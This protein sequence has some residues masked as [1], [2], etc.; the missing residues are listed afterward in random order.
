MSI[1]CLNNLKALSSA[2]IYTK[3]DSFSF[4]SNS[5]FILS[6]LELSIV[7]ESSLLWGESSNSRCSGKGKVGNNVGG[8]LLSSSNSNL[9]LS[10]QELSLVPESSLLRCHP[11]HTWRAG[12]RKVCLSL[13]SCS[14]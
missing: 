2:E 4:S 13:A 10:L 9:I 6:L 14:R 7:P 11:C 5:N 1:V 12:D 3:V 8:P